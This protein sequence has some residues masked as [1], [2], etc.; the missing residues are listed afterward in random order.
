[1][2]NKIPPQTIGE[3]RRVSG[4]F[5]GGAQR[6]FLELK[7]E[8]KLE[9]SIYPQADAGSAVTEDRNSQQLIQQLIQKF[10]AIK[11]EIKTEIHSN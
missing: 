5:V 2:G 7:P 8:L 4:D 1:M 11:T 3:N 6:Q 9:I 10:T